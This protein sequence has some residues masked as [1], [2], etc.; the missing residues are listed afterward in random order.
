MQ[1]ETMS[2]AFMNAYRGLAG[3]KG[4]EI[5][6]DG[7]TEA[8]LPPPPGGPQVLIEEQGSACVDGGTMNNEPCELVRWAIRDLDQERNSREPDEADR[9]VILIAPFPPKFTSSE[10]PPKPDRDM[11]I[12]KI[13][14]MT[15][16]A[17]FKQARYRSTDLIAASDPNVYSR[18]LISPKRTDEKNK[19]GSGK[20]QLAT[21]LFHAAGGFLDEQFR[22]H[23]FVLGRRNAQDFLSTD[24]VLNPRN[25]VFGDEVDPTAPDGEKKQIIPLFGTAAVPIILAPWP[26]M[27]QRKTR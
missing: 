4:G 8:S 6:F 2:G 23:D 15:L 10:E 27:A 7:G 20:P 13:A 3:V 9:A 18:C 12:K 14:S 21:G 17:Y 11:S 19:D 5:F 1:S 22:E 24:F 26:K 16:G 25:R